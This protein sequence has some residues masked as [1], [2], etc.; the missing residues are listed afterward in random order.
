MA[1]RAL[2]LDLGL[3][4]GLSIKNAILY[5][6][7]SAIAVD[8]A[9]A[10]DRKLELL[11]VIVPFALLVLYAF[12]SWLVTVLL[13]DK[14]Y[15][16][17]V[18]TFIRLKGKLVDQFLVLL[19][20]FYGVVD[21]KAALWLLKA[22]VWV[23]IIGCLITVVDTFNI[24]D[25]GIITARWMSGRV[26]GILGSAQEF[27]G[28]LAFFLPANIVLWWTETGIKKWFALVGIVLVL[29]SVML[30]AS[31]G[32]MLAIVIGAI[33]AAIFLRRYISTQI[34]LRATVVMLVLTT[35][36][37]LVVLS[38]DF[39]YLLQT[40][41]STGIATGNVETLSSGRTAFWT[42]AL[43]S[44]AE[45]PLSFVTGLGWEE[46]YQGVGHHFATH[47]VYVDL[48]YNLG[49]IGLTLFVLSFVNAIAIARRGLRDAPEQAAPFLMAMVIGMTSFMIAMAFSDLEL[50]AMFV[51]AFAGLGLRVAVASSADANRL[52]GPQRVDLPWSRDQTK[53]TTRPT[54]AT[55]RR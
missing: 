39:E 17:P 19:V 41:L 34:L 23:V 36:V 29:L 3:A 35:V 43:R 24:P 54:S 7:F 51:W 11:P 15:Y 48:L 21:W 32:A 38:T 18:Q 45:Y 14:P 42:A 28:L 49:I 4:P 22:L 10:R 30:S 1:S 27:G 53:P 50:A 47:S 44:M 12:M 8:S 9:M 37:V 25:L 26:E 31:R 16:D 6:T 46:Y 5:A 55:P 33:M 2:H 13:L 20:F 40:R 52:S